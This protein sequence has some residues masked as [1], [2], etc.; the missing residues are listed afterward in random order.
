[1]KYIL[2]IIPMLLLSLNAKDIAFVKSIK[3]SVTAKQK[4]RTVVIKK[5]DWLQEGMLVKTGNESSIVMVFKD[6][7]VLVLGS[8]S[9][10]RLEK[11]L[12]EPSTSSF[13]FQIRLDRGVASFESGKIGELAPDDFIFRTPDATVGI[14]GTKFIVKVQE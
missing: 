3:G 4:E 5:G 12:F 7:S 8:N 2:L 13:D 9:V 1:M 14:R 10:L 6:N 11:Y